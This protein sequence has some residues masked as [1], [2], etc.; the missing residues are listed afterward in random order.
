MQSIRNK[1]T[2]MMV[3]TVVISLCILG[4]A[5]YWNAQK[6]ILQDAEENLT[7]VA[8]INSERM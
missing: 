1:L 5:N 6:V 7:S 2:I 8:Q 4:A 3:V